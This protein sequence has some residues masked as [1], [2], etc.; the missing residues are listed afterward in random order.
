MSAGSLSLR[1][2][3][4]EFYNRFYQPAKHAGDKHRTTCIQ[5][6]VQIANI[7]KFFRL[8]LAAAGLEARYVELGDLCDE[9]ITGAMNWQVERGR[10]RT[11]ANK[12]RGHINAVWNFATR[13]FAKQGITLARPD[14]D[15]YR[16]DTSE[17]LAFLPDELQRILDACARQQGMVGGVPAGDWWLAFTLFVFSSSLRINAARKVPTAKLDLTRGEFWAPASGQKQRKEQLLDLHTSAVVALRKLRLAERGVAMVLGDWPYNTDTLR[18]HFTRILVESGIFASVKDVPR[19][20]K[21]HALRKTL[22]SQ[23]F[24][25]A[26]LHVACD[27]LGHSSVEVTKRYIDPRYRSQPR[28]RELVKDPMPTPPDTRPQ[29]GIYREEAS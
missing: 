24:E 23:I 2:T 27:R 29:L 19:Q 18:R 26:G 7:N 1:T 20:L 5:Y 17:P 11:T 25:T 13:Q 3:L 4:L 14:N 21:F 22:A 15:K 8:Q 6:R 10:S 16:V 12:L 9:L 28:V